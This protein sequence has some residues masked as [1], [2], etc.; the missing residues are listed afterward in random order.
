MQIVYYDKI[1]SR[2]NVAPATVA[3]KKKECLQ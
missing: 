3:S 1:G 2:R